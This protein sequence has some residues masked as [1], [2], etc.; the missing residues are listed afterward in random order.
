M[1]K[2]GPILVAQCI[3]MKRI[4]LLVILTSFGMLASAQSKARSFTLNGRI[5]GPDTLAKKVFLQYRSE[6]G[7]KM[8]SS[9]VKDGLFSF[10]GKIQEPTMARFMA[11]R[12]AEAIFLMPGLQRIRLNSDGKGL[13]VFGSEAHRAYRKLKKQ[14]G[15]A[16]V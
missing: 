12:N 10:T 7:W 8:D 16:H 5:L 14:I 13:R 1:R 2:I 6:Q 3:D 9:V 15:R 11:R 4:I